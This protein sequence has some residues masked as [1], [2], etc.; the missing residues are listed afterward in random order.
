MVG[1]K[2]DLLKEVLV[3]VLV[4]PEVKEMENLLRRYISARLY[5]LYESVR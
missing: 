2:I 1:K 5:S 3:M 4:S